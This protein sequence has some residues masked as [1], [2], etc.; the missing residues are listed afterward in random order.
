MLLH[1]MTWA[2]GQCGCPVVSGVQCSMTSTQ[3]SPP[4]RIR[5]SRPPYSTSGCT[6]RQRPLRGSHEYEQTI[7]VDWSSD[8]GP[9]T[10]LRCRD[11]VATTRGPSATCALDNRPDRARTGTEL[12]LEPRRGMSVPYSR[13]PSRQQMGSPGAC[14]AIH[15]LQAGLGCQ[16]KANDVRLSVWLRRRSSLLRPR[17]RVSDRCRTGWGRGRRVPGASFTATRPTHFQGY[18]SVIPSPGRASCHEGSAKLLG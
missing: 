10:R 3:S 16:P 17:V 8:L 15:P 12:S 18:W 9:A 4:P 13:A 11:R 14:H 1:S 6:R 7:P 2:T 5:P